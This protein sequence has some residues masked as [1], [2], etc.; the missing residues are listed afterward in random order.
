MIVLFLA[1]QDAVEVMGVTDWRECSK[2]P[3][4]ETFRD[5]G[6]GTPFSAKIFPLNFWPVAFRDGGTPFPLR[7]NIC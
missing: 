7:K 5:G 2:T 1:S 4:T 6:G 3:V